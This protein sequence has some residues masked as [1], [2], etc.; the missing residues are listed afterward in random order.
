MNMF[1]FLFIR[2][3]EIKKGFMILAFFTLLSQLLALVRENIF[4]KIIGAGIDLDLYNASFRVTDIVFVS[5]ATLISTFV[6][7]PILNRKDN[8][9]EK[10]N[11]ICKKNGEDLKKDY[12][13]RVFTTFFIYLIFLIVLFFIFMPQIISIMFPYYNGLV[14]EKIVYISRIALLSP[15][16]MSLANIFISINQVRNYFL[17]YALMSILNNLS[18]IFATVFLYPKYGLNG[19]MIGVIGGAFFYL[20][21]HFPTVIKENSFPKFSSFLTIKEIKK[22]F[23]IS[24]PRTVGIYASVL[25][26]TYMNS[27]VSSL[28]DGYVSYFSW[29]F[30][31]STVPSGLLGVAYSVAA[32]PKLSKLFIENKI[33][34]F[35]S[36]ISSVFRNIIFFGLPV[37]LFFIIFS[38]DLV[39]LIYWSDNFSEDKLFTVSVT[40]SIL[41]ASILFQS[42]NFVLTRAFF[43]IENTKI[44]FM[45]NFLGLSFLVFIGE[46]FFNSNLKVLMNID[47][48]DNKLFILSII[49]SLTFFLISFGLFLILKR[50]VKGLCVLKDIELSK[51]IIINFLTSIGVYF[52]YNF[53]EKFFEINTGQLS[54]FMKLSIFFTLFLIIFVI[55]SKILKEKEYLNLERVILKKI[56]LIIK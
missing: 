5:S 11:N 12:I 56:K 32:F 41:S 20:V 45:I 17:P 1:K 36:E 52:L 4:S 42:F 34:E 3:D 15:F 6:L 2:S 27:K 25:M 43:A 54:S 18:I 48:S 10:K 44:P 16:F 9:N 29:A 8:E 23:S 37:S 14:F 21:I 53:F 46:V 33:E 49:Y 24:I 50:K 28:G 38:K 31:L 51:K 40:L 47:N 26:L 13:N 19:M 30:V 39:A 22:M 7:I 55:I 35:S